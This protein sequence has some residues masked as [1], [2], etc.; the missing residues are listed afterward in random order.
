MFV[1]LPGKA[2]TLAFANN[3]ATYWYT[4]RLRA[5]TDSVNARLVTNAAYSE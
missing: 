3:T 1:S 2:L 4:N 5:F